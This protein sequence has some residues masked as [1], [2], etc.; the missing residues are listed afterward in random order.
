MKPN[1]CWCKA[2]WQ[3]PSCSECV[4]YWNCVH[5]TCN[6]PFECNCEF[7]YKG[8]KTVKNGS[9]GSVGS[10]RKITVFY[11]FYGVMVFLPLG[12]D[13]NSTA[14]TDGNW[15]QWGPWSVCSETCWDT[16]ESFS[17]F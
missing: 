11:G 17:K 5:G 14:D 7:P 1:E 10:V 15:G 4:P 8:K 13:C 2:G 9:V 12:M 3:G 6:E 16:A